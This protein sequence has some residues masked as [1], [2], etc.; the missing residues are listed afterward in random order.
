ME[1]FFLVF[2]I[3]KSINSIRREYLGKHFFKQS[4]CKRK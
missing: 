1:L 3:K 4:L 2:V